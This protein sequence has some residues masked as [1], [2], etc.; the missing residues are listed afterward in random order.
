M[1]VIAV[2]MRSAPNH[3]YDEP[4]DAIS[5]DWVRLL[6]SLGVLPLLVP[7]ADRAPE[8]FLRTFEAR[9]L[10]LTGGDDLGDKG[11]ESARDRAESRLLVYCL[12]AGLPVLGVCRGL[13]VINQHYGGS[14]A[15]R[16]DGHVA[17]EH[18]VLL[19][20][21]LGGLPSG[22]TTR[23]NS[24]HQDGVHQHQLAPELDAV[25]VSPDGL[26]EALRHPALP[27][28]AIQWHPERPEPSSA[29]GRQVLREWL[30]TCI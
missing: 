27:V 17:C 24:Y 5:H 15:R 3:T 11:N 6:D 13:Q 14:L 12:D 29:L 25:A 19:H 26:V 21:P 2:S 18:D 16:I 9:G 10:L 8:R 20:A 23:V 30:A 7:N 28:L 1:T 4:R 22:A